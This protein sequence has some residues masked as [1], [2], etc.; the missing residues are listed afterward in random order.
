MREFRPYGSVRGALSN[1]RPYRD[2]LP[3][4]VKH[5]ACPHALPLAAQ[6]H[7]DF[8][9]LGMASRRSEP[10]ARAGQAASVRAFTAFISRAGGEPNMRPYS[11]VNWGT[12]S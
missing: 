10:F 2:Q 7:A 6:Q 11:R 12:L 3:A 8:G 4:S 1:G 9:E 5:P